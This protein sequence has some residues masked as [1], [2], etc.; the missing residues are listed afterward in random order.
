MR[1]LITDLNDATMA[2]ILGEL[3]IVKMAAKMVKHYYIS[4]SIPAF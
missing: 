2:G 3:E 4:S 1:V